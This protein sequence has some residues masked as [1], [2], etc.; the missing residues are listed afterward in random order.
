MKTNFL[1][2]VAYD[3][4]AT[5]GGAKMPQN[6][7]GGNSQTKRAT[8]ALPL[9]YLCALFLALFMGVGNMWGAVTVETYNNSGASSGTA[10]VKTGSTLPGNYDAGSASKPQGHSENGGVKL[11]TQNTK[12]TLDEVEYGYAVITTNSGYT[13]KSFQLDATSNGSNS[14]TLYGVYVDVDASSASALATALGTAT[15][16]ISSNVVFPNK[17]TDY[18]STPNLSINASSNIVLRFA[19][20]GDN[21][22]RAVIKVGYELAGADPDPTI[23]FSD[24]EY[25]TDGAALDL[26]TLFASN[27][28]GAVTYT[29]K[30][31]GGTGAAIDGTS[32]TATAE[33]TAVVTASQAAVSG[34][35]AAKSVDANIV[36][37]EPYSVQVPAT[38]LTLPNFPAEGWAGKV[39]PSYYNNGSDGWYVLSPYELYQ[40][41]TNL[42][43]TDCSNPGSS[44]MPEYAAS[45][46]FPASSTWAYGGGDSKVKIATVNSKAGSLKG[47]YVY[48]VKKCLGV[49][50]YGSS[51]SN[52]KRTVYLKAF[53]VT[54]GVAATTPAKTVSFES[55][56]ATVVSMTGLSASKEYVIEI[57]QKNVGSGGSSEGNSSVYAIAFLSPSCTKPAAPT[58]LSCTD[59]TVNS[60]TFG[61]TKAEHAEGYVATLYSNEGCT[62]EVESKNLGDVATVTFT[63]LSNS[64]TYYCKVQSKGNGTTYC[65]D[66]NVTAAVSGETDAPS[67]GVVTAPTFLQAG[68]ITAEGATL[69]VTDAADAM[70]YEFYISEESTEPETSATATHT[71]TTKE[72]A[73]TGL[74]SGTTYYVWVRSVCDADHKSIWVALDGD[75]FKVKAEPTT[76][77]ANG[78]YVLGGSALDLSALIANNN[79]AGAITYEITDAGTTSASISTAAFSAT[80]MGTATVQAT[81]AAYGDFAEKVMSATIT[82]LDDEL[83]DI[84]IWSKAS[85]YGGDGKCISATDANKDANANAASTTLNYSTLAMD[86][87]TTMGRPGGDAVVTL[88]FSVKGD[89]SSLF[90][91]KSICTM[92]KLEEPAGGQISWDNGTTWTALDAYG[93]GDGEV[94]TFNAPTGVFPASFKIKFVSASTSVGGL[95]WRNALVTLEVKKTVTGVTEALTGAEI[96]GVAISSENLATL[97]ASKTLAIATAYAAAPTVTFKKEVTTTYAGGW[98]PDVEDVDVE[99]AASDITT[100]W[101]ASQTIGGQAYTITLAKPTAPSLV[102]EATSFTLTSAKIATDTKNFTFSG[103]N[104]TAGNVT[105]SLE[106]PIAGMTVSPTEVTPTAGVITDQEVTIT[107]KSLE[108]VAEANVNLVVYYDTDT[109]IVLPLTYSSTKGYE[110]LTSISAATTWNWNGAADVAVGTVINKDQMI[111]LANADA[112]WDEGFNARAIA[113]KLEYMYRDSKYSQGYEWKFNTTIPGKVFVT[114]SNTGNNNAR[115][116][117]INGTKGTNSSSN[118]KDADIVT[119]KAFVSAGDVLIQG[120]QVSDDEA[121]YLRVYK[122]EFKPIFSVTYNAGE[123]SVKGGET[124]PTQ[125]DEAAGEKITLAASTALEKDGYDFTGWLC[126]IDGLTYDAGADYTMTAAATTFTAQWTLHVDPVDPT[127]TYDEGAYTVGG[128][129]LDL[130]TLI[131]AQTSTGAITY[132]VKT[133]GGTGASVDGKNFTATAAGTATIT[134][135]QAAVLGY[136]AKTVDFNVVVTEPVEID[137]V[138]LVEAGTLTGN[139]ITSSTLSTDGAPY[140]VEGLSY[141]KYIKFGGTFSGSYGNGARNNYLIYDLN[142]QNTTFYMYVHNNSG[143]EYKIV[144]Y[145]YDNASSKLTEIPVAG[146]A[147]ALKSFSL[148]DVTENTRVFIG[149]NNTNIYFC[150]VVAVESGD[151]LLK[152]GQAG[153]AIDFGAKSRFAGASSETITLDGMTFV[154]SG[155]YAPNSN[156]E[157]ALGTIGTNY[158]KFVLPT[159]AEVQ[160]TT[161]STNK[162]YI[163]S[164]YASDQATSKTYEYTPTAAKEMHSFSLAAGTWYLNPNTS[165]IKLTKLAFIAPKCAEP[166]FN[167]L[168]NSD[169]CSG[170]PYVAL[171]GTATV[172]DAGVPTYKWYAEGADESDPAAVLATTST[173]TPSAD[174]NYYVIATNHLAGYTDNTKKSDLVSVTTHS[175]TA[176]TEGL[177]NVRKG[178]GEAATLTVEATGK[179]LHY[180]WKES[181][182]IDGTYTDVAG[183]T[184][185]K[186]LEVVVPDGA[187]YYKVIVSSDCGANQES[188]AK[189]EKFVPVAQVVVDN[190]VVWDLTT[191]ADAE[192]KLDGTTSPKKGEECL[193]ANIEGVHMDANF[194]SESLVF[195]GEY[196]YRTS[197]ASGH[198]TCATYM[199]FETSVAGLVRVHFAGN[200]SNRCLRITSSDNVQYSSVSTGTGNDLT[201]EFEV[202]AGEIELMGMNSGHT[203]DKQYMRFYQIEFLALAHRRTAAYSVGELGTICLED[204]AKAVGANVYELLGH[205]ENGKM[206]F[207]QIESGE[208]EAGKPY[209]FQA[210]NASQVSFYKQVNATHKD[211]PVSLKGMYGTFVDKDLYPTTD[212]D[213]FY[214]SGT[215][216]WAVKDFTVASI[217]IPAYR[218]YVNY[219]EFMENPV[220]SSTPLPGRKRMLIGV[221]GAPAVATGVEN[222]AATDKPAK[223]LING[224]LFILRGEKM[225]DAK[226]QLVK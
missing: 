198:P 50:L 109:K 108:D 103:V 119:D 98:A 156:T 169:I 134:A 194:H 19:G 13:L 28:S 110:D 152:G 211:D 68:S 114:Y 118:N 215:H 26:S 27:S 164:T 82:V 174:G 72:K 8:L 88:T 219:A 30:T 70:N 160:V 64:T 218:C 129:A 2:L 172:A 9:R 61:W 74:T 138:K 145:T 51:G 37:S 101:Q 10:I 201:E 141:S 176:I 203:S 21:Q 66:G 7:G 84:Y 179:N 12:V 217:T 23:T 34:S 216:I 47:P 212:V 158:V 130:S 3:P 213:M 167:S 170:D 204:D 6:T 191:C 96:N 67:C 148:N 195:A 124:L 32:F 173:Y 181:E 91:I 132:S 75:K 95:W 133:D 144:V 185:S 224:Q 1:N 99:V 111:I 62:S 80:A 83:S 226:G 183:A 177:A 4:I 63:G 58:A 149:V 43:W 131:T 135:S 39:T 190:S 17:N 208:I 147:N 151:D 107:Y 159:A 78:I 85:K 81:Q 123:G 184:D 225:Y 146:S 187:K 120:V 163:G 5:Q 38:A 153:Y 112:T 46:P 221:N 35:Y 168:A 137:G 44:D 57:S 102:T 180:A 121:K 100:A 69:L 188:I 182:T 142:K 105:I 86:G 36:V 89:Y 200:G 196:I 87:M 76:T 52:G 104:L 202:A 223:M 55:S 220:G 33:G 41:R 165:N 205:D 90:G 92:G 54:A 161:N 150:Q 59:H 222:A 178:A 18:V 11:R 154:P 127:L 56:A 207:Y 40:S 157:V 193:M 206:V 210:T 186:S 60:L 171:N 143:T 14:I 24:G 162:Y 15:N 48:R 214:F 77:F 65:E 139:Y 136:N 49:A 122:I 155:G 79:S 20:S 31:D 97:L 29:V 115:T 22:L 94:K 113:G 192:I 209:L 116:T 42:T 106:S 128:A 93:S 73:I 125:A 53:E 45:A 16:L 166:A 71:S 126:N 175:G 117:N 199:K 189:V 140:V 197:S 25:A